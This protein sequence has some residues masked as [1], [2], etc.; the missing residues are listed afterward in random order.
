[1]SIRLAR[2]L[3]VLFML[4]PILTATSRAATIDPAAMAYRLPAT[5]E[6]RDNPNNPGVKS[7][8]LYG[9]P[10]KPGPYV[11]RVKWLPGNMSRPHSHPNDRFIVVLSGT[12]WAGTGE[13]FAPENTIPMPQAA[14]SPTSAGRFT[15]T[16]PRTKRPC[17]RSTGWG[18]RRRRTST[19]GTEHARS[20]L[21]LP[22]RVGLLAPPRTDR[23]ELAAR[24]RSGGEQRRVLLP[25]PRL[26]RPDDGGVN[27]RHAQ[28]EAQGDPGRARRRVAHERIVE[29]PQALPVVRVI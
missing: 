18:R 24:Q 9:D 19:P 27:A 8:V 21:A 25:S 1:M 13:K 5:I 16:A 28:R 6:W 4:T 23:V 17:S 12:W 11:V 20:D 10:T 15:T 22:R 7:A 3:L 26:R 29:V 2:L 14:S